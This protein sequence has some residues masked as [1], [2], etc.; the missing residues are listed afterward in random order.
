MAKHFP[1]IILMAAVIIL[2]ASCSGDIIE[3]DR[4]GVLPHGLPV[5]DIVTENSAGIESD[6]DYVNAD[7]TITGP[8]SKLT[9]SGKIRGRGN[10]T[11]TYEKK[12]YKIK[13][14]EK[15]VVLGMSADR[16]WLLQAEY[17]DKSLMR[18]AY[19]CALS[20]AVGMPYTI[21]YRHIEVTLNGE[22]L[23]V[24][25]IAE[26]VEKANDRVN[27]A[28]DGFIIENDNYWYDEPLN[29]NSAWNLRYTFKY[30]GTDGDDGINRVD[31]RYIYIR[32]YI[33]EFEA[34]LSG[35]D[36]A[37]P[38]LGYR[39][40]IDA[41]TFAKWYLVNELLCNYDPNLYYVLPTVGAKLMMYPLWDA[42]WCLGLAG[43]KE[44]GVG[45]AEPPAVSPVDI[46]LWRK[47]KYFVRLFQDPYFIDLIKEQWVALKSRLPQIKEDMA[48][49]AQS[50]TEAQAANF[51]RWPLLDSYV[52]VGLVALGSWEAEVDYIKDFFDKRISW[53]DY[54]IGNL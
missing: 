26:Q 47:E 13:F 35:G 23:G 39:A 44:N 43:R 50:L 4:Y 38:E 16:D 22:Y 54:Y 25:L 14:N 45:W 33:K 24:Y 31:E 46:D 18:T 28:D 20:N 34:A 36:F 32:D 40:Y 48:N 12:P 8:Y 21:S 37:D 6:R 49:V 2:A 51:E 53:F 1:H 11:W 9:A 7:F 3:P 30:P 42:E 15:Q 27:I 41:E 17:T 19:M 10:K 29:F 52:S 5:L